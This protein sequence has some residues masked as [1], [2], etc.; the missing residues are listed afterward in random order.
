MDALIKCHECANDSFRLVAN[1][2][3][4]KISFVCASCGALNATVDNCWINERKPKRPKK[5]K[6]QPTPRALGQGW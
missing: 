3:D 4:T 2:K 1:L 6:V 5:A